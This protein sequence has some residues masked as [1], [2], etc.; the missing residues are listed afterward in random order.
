MKQ[1]FTIRHMS[2]QM[3]NIA[4]ISSFFMISCKGNKEIKEEQ[5]TFSEYQQSDKPSGL[6]VDIPFPSTSGTVLLTGM[7]DIRLIPVYKINPKS[8]RDLQNEYSTTY[9][10]RYRYNT[11]DE[12]NYKYFMP[13]ID[14][15]Y[16]YNM[17]NMGHFD[18]TN[19][20]LSYFFNHPVLIRTLY[21]P[22]ERR[23]SLYN[24]P[25]N[26]NYFMVS[27]YDED[28]NR[29]SLINTRDMRRMYQIDRLNTSK[30]TILPPEYSAIRSTYDYKNDMMYIYA[31][32]DE[33]NNG[34]PEREEPISIFWI[35][36]SEPAI[37]RKMS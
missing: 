35:R 33:N 24:Q 17:V 12:D 14:I 16:G 28:T 9:Y 30:T 34:T 36:L 27:V 10:D 19:N 25:V 22:G 3:F 13:G 11:E 21:F 7:D 15:I 6:V 37:V 32:F 26:R 18:L 31:R 1:I 5:L 4:L 8:N 29:D 23:D 20:K 2:H